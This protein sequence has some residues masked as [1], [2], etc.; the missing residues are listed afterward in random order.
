MK[1]LSVRQPWAWAI[2]YAGKNIENR[3]RRTNFRGRIAVH[4]SK[5]PHEV[6]RLPRGAR[7]PPPEEDWIY[8]AILGFVDIVDCVDTH[9]SKWFEG[10]YGYVLA[11]PTPLEHPVPCKGQ[12]GLWE[13]PTSVRKRCHP[14]MDR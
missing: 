12:L 14:R 11:N 3:P 13:V 5:T 1:A 2:I 7:K 4:A 6:R 8:G 9:R 10:P